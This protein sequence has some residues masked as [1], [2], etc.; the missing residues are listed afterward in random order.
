MGILERAS[1]RFQSSQATGVFKI[2]F[3]LI[4]MSETEVK[5]TLQISFDPRRF[6]FEE[7]V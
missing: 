3:I 4:D 6:L 2:T 1:S 7:D 5:I